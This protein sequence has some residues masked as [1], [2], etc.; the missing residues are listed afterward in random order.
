MIN[1]GL[2]AVKNAKSGDIDVALSEGLMEKFN[3]VFKSAPS[4]G[5]ARRLVG[6]APAAGTCARR[7]NYILEQLSQDEEVSSALSQSSTILS[8]AASVDRAA[9]A[10]EGAEMSVL[11]VEQLALLEIAV[12]PEVLLTLGGVAGLSIVASFWWLFEKAVDKVVDPII[13]V[14]VDDVVKVAVQAA[15]AALSISETKT[16]T[17]TPDD[18]SETCVTPD[19]LEQWVRKNSLP[20]QNGNCTLLTRFLFAI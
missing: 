18:E 5:P 17:E 13:G 1:V 7:T 16:E 20:T 2:K 4:C 8:D 6:R 10:A 12:S 3:N 15:T 11:S 14:P 19:K 9:I